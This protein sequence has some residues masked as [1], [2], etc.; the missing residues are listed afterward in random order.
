MPL[1]RCKFKFKL[2]VMEGEEKEEL[3]NVELASQL[4]SGVPRPLHQ[5]LSSQYPYRTRGATSGMMRQGDDSVATST[6]KYR[7]T[8]CYHQVPA[9]VRF[10]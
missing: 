9:S 4:K 10:I 3:K 8:Q 6:F 2:T 7:E 5:A 1:F